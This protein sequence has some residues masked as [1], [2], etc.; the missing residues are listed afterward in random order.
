MANTMSIDKKIL[1][2]IERHHRINK[3]INEQEVGGLVPGLPEPDAAAPAGAEPA[4]PAAAPTGTPEKID[5]ATDTEVEKITDG[6]EVA[7]EEGGSQELDVTELVNAQKNIETKQEEYF[8][9]LFGYIQNLES[10]LSEMDN[11]VNKLNDIES[12]LEKYRPKSAE[13][14]LQLRTIDSG[15]FNKKLSDFFDDKKEDW[16]K[17]GKQE[18]ILTSDEVEDISP[19]EI[20]KT[21]SSNET[22]QLPFKF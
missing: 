5:L 7:T 14:K 2:E 9:N 11:L 3:Y 1:K 20:K 17:S 19:A 8:D 6:G 21:F 13:E 10:K 4:T 22:D 16:E 18:Y 12:K 15:P